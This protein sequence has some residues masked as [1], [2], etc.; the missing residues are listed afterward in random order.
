MRMLV[1]DLD[2]EETGGNDGLL[3]WQRRQVVVTQLHRDV[4]RAG[5]VERAHVGHHLEPMTA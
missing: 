4:G 3:D 2:G 5:G 1:T